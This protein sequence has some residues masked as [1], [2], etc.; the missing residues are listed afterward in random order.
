MIKMKNNVFISMQVH[1]QRPKHEKKK[2]LFDLEEKQ[3]QNRF[4]QNKQLELFSS[5][6][7]HKK[8]GFSAQ[9]TYESLKN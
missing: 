3:Q 2:K 7:D 5:W 9:C 4:K 1:K 6:I 8:V